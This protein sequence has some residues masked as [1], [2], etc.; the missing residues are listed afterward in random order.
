MNT[1]IRCQA[2]YAYAGTFRSRLGRPGGSAARPRDV[3]IPTPRSVPPTVTKFARPGNFVPVSQTR[4]YATIAA[5][6]RATRAAPDRS[7]PC[8]PRQPAPRPC[9]THPTE[10]DLHLWGTLMPTRYHHNVTSQWSWPRQCHIAVVRCG[11]GRDVVPEAS[12][13]FRF[14]RRSQDSGR[15]SH[16][17]GIWNTTVGASA[18]AVA[19]P[20]AGADAPAGGSASDHG[21]AETRGALP[22]AAGSGCRAGAGGG[23]GSAFRAAAAPAPTPAGAAGAGAGSGAGA[24]AGAGLAFRAG[25]GAGSGSAV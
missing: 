4:P 17:S 7:A 23:A 21:G 8:L 13:H 6:P 1:H 24:G 25:V 2:S 15:P 11:S 12:G 16:E 20:T 9:T 22:S 3:T 14:G 19:S 5:W 10:H 18:A